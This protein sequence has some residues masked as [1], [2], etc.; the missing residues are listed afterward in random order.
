V[1]RT[2]ISLPDALSARLDRARERINVSRVCA[3]ALERELDR[4]EGRPGPDDPE[5]ARLLARLLGTRERWYR[6]GR[7]DGRRW[8]LETAT[9]EE[10]WQ[11]AGQLGELR[12]EELAQLARG[13]APPVKVA[14][15]RV[16]FPRSFDPVA[17]AQAWAAGAAGEPE[18]PARPGDAPPEP[19]AAAPPPEPAAAAPPAGQDAAPDLASYLEGWRDAAAGLWEAVAPGLR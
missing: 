10:L 5:A 18:T 7:G 19:A 11:V 17:A 12:A 3:G 6:R 9:R 2:T 4:L 16:A 14:L 8:A 13:K 15:E 1:A